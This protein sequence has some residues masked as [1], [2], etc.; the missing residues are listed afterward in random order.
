MLL[1]TDQEAEKV[2]NE[3]EIKA[4][5]E[6]LQKYVR[7][8]ATNVISRNIINELINRSKVLELESDENPFSHNIDQFENLAVE[9]KQ[10]KEINQSQYMYNKK[11]AGEPEHK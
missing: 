2:L 6:Y 11:K 3:K 5:L 4:C 7:P 9:N 8:F 1:F 10:K